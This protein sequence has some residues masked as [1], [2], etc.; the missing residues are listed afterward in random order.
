MPYLDNDLVESDEGE[1]TSK[2][3]DSPRL[4]SGH[5]SCKKREAKLKSKVSSDTFEHI[6]LTLG[7]REN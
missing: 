4:S 3:D 2:K 5:S 7:D 1:G 6:L